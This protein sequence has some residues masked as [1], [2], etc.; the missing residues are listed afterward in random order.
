MTH[1][2]YIVSDEILYDWVSQGYHYESPHTTYYYGKGEIS[3]P[4]TLSPSNSLKGLQCDDFSYLG[5]NYESVRSKSRMCT[6]V[7]WPQI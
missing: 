3:T 5:L 7:V 6:L 1:K 2:W 4:F